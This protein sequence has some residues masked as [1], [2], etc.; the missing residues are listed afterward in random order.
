MKIKTLVPEIKTLLFDLDGTAFPAR[1]TGKPNKRIIDVVSLAQKKVFVSIATGR[2]LVMSEVIIALLK[3]EHT[4]ILNGGAELYNPKTKEY[5]W[6][7]TLSKE[8]TREA[9]GLL[10]GY[11]YKVVDDFTVHHPVFPVNYS[12]KTDTAKLVVIVVS[13]NDAEKIEHQIGLVPGL[14]AHYM[15]SYV[16]GFFDIHIT[17]ELATKKHAM[18]ALLSLE[19]QHPKNVMVV[20]DGGNDLPLFELAGWKVAMG[21]AEDRLKN[22]ADWIAPSVDDDGLGVAIEKFILNK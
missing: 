9:I 5:V 8:M 11:P 17:S 2:P 20:G 22:A 12:I 15:Q 10:K 18:Q 6:R 3:L 13:K 16:P 14:V 7:Q 21:N 1:M 19:N 4:C